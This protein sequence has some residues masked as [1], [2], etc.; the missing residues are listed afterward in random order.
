[1]HTVMLLV[2]ST[3]RGGYPNTFQTLVCKYAIT[4]TTLIIWHVAILL[5]H[6]STNLLHSFRAGIFVLCVWAGELTGNQLSACVFACALLSITA[7]SF[8]NYKLHCTQT[9]HQVGPGPTSTVPPALIT[10]AFW[11]KILL[12][13]ESRANGRLFARLRCRRPAGHSAGWD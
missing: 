4:V 2:P 12:A 11:K 7:T 13:R 1:M 8:C 5:C 3:T 10:V 6:S 9:R